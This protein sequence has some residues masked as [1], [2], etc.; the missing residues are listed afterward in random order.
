LTLSAGMAVVP[1]TTPVAAAASV[2]CSSTEMKA[3]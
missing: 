3:L 2:P 1:T